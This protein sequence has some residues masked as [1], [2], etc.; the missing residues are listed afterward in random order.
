[1]AFFAIA[2][3]ITFDLALGSFWALLAFVPLAPILIC[4]LL[5][6]EAFFSKNLSG[7]P[8]YRQRVRWRLIP[9]IF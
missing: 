4:S 2:A 9:G 7:Y 6:E 8:E 1:V 5:D 3:F